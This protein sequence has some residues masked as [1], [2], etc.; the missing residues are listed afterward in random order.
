MIILRFTSGLGNQMFQYNLYTYL[1]ERY[2]DAQVRADLNW[3][4]RFSEHQG[5]ELERLFSKNADFELTPATDREIVRCLGRFP[6]RIKG[7]PGDIWQFM[8][9]VPH[10]FIRTFSRHERRRIDQTGFEDNSEIRA[11]IEDIDPAVDYYI[12][13]YFIEEVYYRSR[14]PFLRRVFS[15]DRDFGEK[16]REYAAM[17]E[18]GSSVSIHVRRGDYL[19]AE[20]SSSF[21]CLGEEYYKKAVALVREKLDDPRFFIFSDDKEFIKEAFSWLDN[22]VIVEGNT[23]SESYRDMQLMS[24]CSA[25]I[26]ANSTFSVWA[27][28][29]NAHEDRLICYPASYMKEKDTQ[30]MTLEGWVRV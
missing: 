10:R 19:S 15:F 30:Q 26:I 21:I 24:L 6:N 12:T 11:M 1:K 7:V 17:I 8:L 27:G 4:A 20:Y 18:E 9:R 2:P 5:Y 22:K 29:L 13:G 25:N 16:N 3:F 28:L 23:G 14:L